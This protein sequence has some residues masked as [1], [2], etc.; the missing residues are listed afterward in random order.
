M[1]NLSD[2]D[3]L[4]SAAETGSERPHPV[5][6][7]AD[8]DWFDRLSYHCTNRWWKRM[9]WLPLFPLI[10]VLVFAGVLTGPIW[11]PVYWALTGEMPL[12]GRS[13]RRRSAPA[14]FGPK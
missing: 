4:P 3:A 13:S 10:P 9:L 8:Q 1:N 14:P 6:S 7:D 11:V 12:S 2:R 5:M